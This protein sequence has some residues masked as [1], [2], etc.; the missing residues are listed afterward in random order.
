[1]K[2]NVFASSNA[3]A[4]RLRSHAGQAGSARSATFLGLIALF[5]LTLTPAFAAVSG[6]VVNATTGKPVPNLEVTITQPGG[7]GMKT[8]GT[9]KTDAAGN[10]HFDQQAAP[11]PQ[12]VNVD[13]EGVSYV[14]LVAPGTTSGFQMDVYNATTKPDVA[15]VS[16]DLILYQPT[17]SQVTVNETIFVQNSSN[18]A[19]KNPKLGAIRFWLPAEANGNVN[20]SVTAPGGM[21]VTRVADKTKEKNVYSVDYAIKP[22]ETRFD[23]AYSLPAANPLVI[24]GKILHQAGATRIAVPPGVTVKSDDLTSLGEEPQ[25]HAAVYDVKGKEF[26]IQLAGT[27]SMGSPDASSDDN[28]GAPQITEIQPRVYSKLLWILGISL[29]ILALGFMLL[30]RSAKPAPAEPAQDREPAKKPVR[31]GAVSR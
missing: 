21:P 27:G 26:K 18:L 3:S 5:F 28:S 6:A 22:G 13:F 2:S 10:F 14:K 11:G 23:L 12:L 1:M 17:S 19:Y 9:V 15:Q 16:Q 30:Y 29:A 24:Q 25:T 4:M 31:K 7:G 20:V 8:L